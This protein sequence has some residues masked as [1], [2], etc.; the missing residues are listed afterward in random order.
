MVVQGQ[1]DPV[2]VKPKTLGVQGIRVLD[3]SDSTDQWVRRYVGTCTT[4]SEHVSRVSVTMLEKNER[5]Q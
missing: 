1:T 3:P 2:R 5:P 4:F